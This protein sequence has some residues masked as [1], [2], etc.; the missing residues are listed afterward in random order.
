M[1][2]IEVQQR[3][4]AEVYAPRAAALMRKWRSAIEIAARA[5]LKLERMDDSPK[6]QLLLRK[7]RAFDRARVET[8]RTITG[9]ISRGEKTILDFEVIAGTAG[10]TTDPSRRNTGTVAPA[11]QLG[12]WPLLIGAVLS[13]GAV[14][15]LLAGAESIMDEII[16][17]SSTL[18]Y[19]GVIA[20]GLWGLYRLVKAMGPGADSAAPRIVGETWS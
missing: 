4:A 1:S 16:D 14:V 11:S 20:G 17:W 9:D 6:K 8:A 19:V 12:L 7:L 13:A 5:H 15:G 2:P 18:L 3:Q 10:I